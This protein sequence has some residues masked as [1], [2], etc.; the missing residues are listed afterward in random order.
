MNSQSTASRNRSTLARAALVLV[1]VLSAVTLAL[2][3]VNRNTPVPASWGTDGGMRQD[4]TAVVNYLLLG[5]IMPLVTTVLGALI[6][7]RQP[8]NRVGWLLIALGVCYLLI[9]LFGELT[10]AMNLTAQS[11]MAGGQLVAWVSNWIWV[12]S[13]S[14]LILML[15]LFPGGHFLSRRW[16]VAIGLPLVVFTAN[17][18][19]AAGIEQT[20]SSAYQVLNPFVAS[21]PEA[22]YSALFATGVPLMVIALMIVLGETVVRF[23][24]AGQ[25]ERQQI[26]WLLI[27]L[28]ATAAMVVIGLTLVFAADIAVGASLVNAAPLLPVL[29][30]GVA[31]LR[32]R[33]YDVDLVIRRTL[34]YTVITAVLLLV[35]FGSVTLLTSVFSRVTG[36]QSALAIVISTL[37]IAAL[38]NPL[39][40][41]VQDWI[42][43][44]FFRRKYNA[45]QVLAQFALTAR[46]ETDLDALTTELLRV[47]Q[48]TMQPEHVSVWLRDPTE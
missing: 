17:L 35:Y 37:V 47:V 16:T 19:V 4:L 38:F 8:H 39:R 5:L 7:S 42:D 1:V 31:M 9:G 24:R 14:L 40:R 33:L 34:A 45:Q 10:V 15:A 36:Q 20:L 6:V 12:L 41:R 27:G 28:A 46:D 29:A 48:E 26:K 11:V 21:H 23:R 13:Y 22:L 44:R 25:E 30:I 32:Y 2:F 3:F 43:R 18:L